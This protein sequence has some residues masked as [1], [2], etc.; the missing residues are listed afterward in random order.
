MMEVFYQG[1]S[2]I[3]RVVLVAVFAYAGL[4]LFIR[5]SGKRSLAK[6]NA[7]DFIVTVA[8]G[9][10]LATILLNNDIALVEG[11]TAF[12]MLL[13][14]Q[15]VVAW[16]SVRSARVRRMVKSEPALLVYQGKVLEAALKKQR[17]ARPEVYQVM[18]S[19]G[20]ASVED[21]EAVVL[22]TDGTLSVMPKP[23]GEGASS[24]ASIP[25]IE[26]GGTIEN[27]KA[28]EDRL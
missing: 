9:S 8:L 5:I 14:L 2:G 1:G 21:V 17:V 20:F 13:G 25:G 24:L 15:F 12:A 10:T 27:M 23:S 26:K 16:S 3:W 22:E 28:A 18:R 6:L 19:Q 11:M 4:I 7:F